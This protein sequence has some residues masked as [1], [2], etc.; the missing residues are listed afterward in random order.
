MVAAAA[1]AVVVAAAVPMLIATVVAKIT[2]Y[3]DG[4]WYSPSAVAVVAGPR[5]TG[6]RLGGDSSIEST[7]KFDDV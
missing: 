4:L 3:G 7:Y 1:A 6:E 2:V 5:R